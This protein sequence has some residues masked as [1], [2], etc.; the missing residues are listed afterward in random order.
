MDFCPQSS[1]SIIQLIPVNDTSVHDKWMDSNPYS[2]LSVLA[3]HPMYLSLSGVVK[4]CGGDKAPGA[5]ADL[6]AIRVEVEAARRALD[7]ATVDYEGTMR[8][9][10]E[11]CE[12]LFHYQRESCHSDPNFSTF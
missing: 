5:E 6:A 1:Q 7:L 12:K 11:I 4:T 9:K 2:S 8:T 10:G 3:L